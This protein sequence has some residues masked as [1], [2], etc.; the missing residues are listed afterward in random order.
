MTEEE[1]MRINKAKNELQEIKTKEKRSGRII[2]TTGGIALAVIAT[3][4][5]TGHL[6]IGLAIGAIEVGGAFVI[7]KNQIKAS[8]MEDEI[9]KVELRDELRRLTSK[10]KLEAQLNKY[11]QKTV[12]KPEQ[13][14][15]YSK[16]QLKLMAT[17]L[18]EGEELAISENG[19]IIIISALPERENK[20]PVLER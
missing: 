1:L 12:E 5:L 18:K 14:E 6:L 20:A 9:K 13:S 8:E 10:Q 17:I 19:D 15:L 11:I 7:F 2:L 3:F 4:S 16:E